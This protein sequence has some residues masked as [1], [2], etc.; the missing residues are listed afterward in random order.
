M[1][2]KAIA[3]ASEVFKDTKDRGGQPYILHCLYVMYKVKHLGHSTMICGV[4]HDVVEDSDITLEYIFEEFGVEIGTVISLLT[5]DRSVPYMDYIKALS[6]NPIAKAVKMVD[7]EHN[8][9]ITRLKDVR[10]KDFDRL[11]KYSLAYKYL[12]D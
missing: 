3:L 9:K 5:H 11:E 1:L 2:G 6:V 4:L 8:S 7:L 12:K 10:K